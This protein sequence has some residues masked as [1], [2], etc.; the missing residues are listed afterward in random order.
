MHAWNNWLLRS[1][2]ITSTLHLNTHGPT[3]I[4]AFEDVVVSSS[5]C[6]LAR[7]LSKLMVGDSKLDFAYER[8]ARR[9]KEQ[10]AML[11]LTTLFNMEF[12]GFNQNSVQYGIYGI[13]SSCSRVKKGIL[14][15]SRLTGNGILC[16]DRLTGNGGMNEKWQFQ[17]FIIQCRGLKMVFQSF[18]IQ[19]KEL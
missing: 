10:M 11:C 16:F 4:L 6:Y 7:G 18:V 3:C 17:Q 9:W 15:F 2:F 12:M 5:P 14:R 13:Q 8:V 1:Y 19:C